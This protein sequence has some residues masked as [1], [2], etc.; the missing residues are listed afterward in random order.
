MRRNPHWQ[1]RGLSVALALGLSACGF[2]AKGPNRPGNAAP[3]TSTGVTLSG[4]GASDD[5]SLGFGDGSSITD[6]DSGSGNAAAA[7]GIPGGIDS[8]GALDES[9]GGIGGVA[10][11]GGG[12]AGAGGTLGHGGASAAG[13]AS[14]G[15]ANSPPP[16][17]FFSEYV[18]G[19][20]SNKALEI[21][22]PR[23]STL[24][25]CKVA[26]YFNGKSEASV[27]ATLSGVLEANQVLTIC[28]SSLNQQLGNVCNQ[29]GNLTFNG[30]DALALSC[31]GKLLDVI[32][33][34]G[35]DPGAAWGSGMNTTVDHT[36]QRKCSIA[37]GDALGDDAFEPNDEWQ[38]LPVDT[39][40]GLG[41]R[42]C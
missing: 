6:I 23:R 29:V 19:S 16:V 31:D 4:A 33:Q 12:A 8:G 41:A 30:D 38:A 15:A 10:S 32:G 24:D 22:A 28:S 17:L 26:A 1:W 35:V 13:A 21:T 5:E 27:V 7:G 11:A 9:A 20:S 25:G 39:F 3:A 37:S 42:G 18:E 14:A 34:I 36:L 40:S 2:D